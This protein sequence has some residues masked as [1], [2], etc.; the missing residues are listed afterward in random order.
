MGGGVFGNCMDTLH[1][2]EFEATA[3]GLTLLVRI[4]GH[5]NISTLYI[6][7]AIL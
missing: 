6:L 3:C 1:T 7:P 2:E 4:V 5:D